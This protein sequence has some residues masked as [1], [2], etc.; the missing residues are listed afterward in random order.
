MVRR[1]EWQ[2]EVVMERLRKEMIHSRENM[3]AFS[4]NILVFQTFLE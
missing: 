1:V 2:E 3:Y 4:G